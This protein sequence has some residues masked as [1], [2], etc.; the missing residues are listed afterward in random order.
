MRLERPGR[1]VLGLYATYAYGHHPSAWR[2]SGSGGATPSSLSY[3]THLARCA[4]EALLDFIFLADTPSV[5]NDERGG[6][7]GRVVG[8]EP[9]TL[10]SALASCTSHIGLIG[11]L[12]TTFNEPYNVARQIASLDHL[13][14]GRAG[15]NI[16][17]SS[18]HGAARSFGLDGLPTHI[19]RY[20]RAEEFVEVVNTLWHSWSHDAFIRDRVAGIY[21]RPEGRRPVAFEGKYLSVFGELNVE[22]CPQGRPVL[23]QA[24]ASPSG[25]RL[26][27]RWADMIFTAASEYSEAERFIRTLE[28]AMSDVKRVGKR[29][30]VLPGVSV[31]GGKSRAEARARFDELLDL[32]HPEHAISMLSDQLG[33]DLSDRDP[34]L[35]LGNKMPASKGNQSKRERILAMAGA[36]PKLTLIQLARKISVARSHLILVDSWDGVADSLV[37]WFNTG[38]CD[39]FNVMPPVLPEDLYGFVNEVIPRLQDRGVAARSQELGTLR[40]RVR[41]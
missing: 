41:A 33:V 6:R 35:P 28:R 22:P 24:G 23:V 10:L 20:G 30:L 2:H 38:V 18:K 25:V 39:G 32:V 16:V 27:A 37:S 11:T 21:Y 1:M 40:D 14:G 36:D 15:W 9:I 26:G 29:P 13:S 31:Y 3:F 34:S 12:S 7:S 17:T 4:E 5:F 8:L 19:D